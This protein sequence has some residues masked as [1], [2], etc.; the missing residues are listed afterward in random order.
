[1][2]NT[3]SYS[4]GK[5]ENFDGSPHKGTNF[6]LCPPP[7]VVSM[8]LS[9]L[10]GRFSINI[11]SKYQCLL[12]LLTLS[13]W[14]KKCLLLS[15]CKVRP[16][17]NALSSSTMLVAPLSFFGQTAYYIYRPCWEQDPKHLQKAVVQANPGGDS[18]KDSVPLEK[19]KVSLSISSTS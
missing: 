7:T 10:H 8:V 19:N 18:L 1:M 13:Q 12:K 16:T 6:C 15:L 3:T 14:E 2:L 5:K 11:I 4:K 17:V 9:L